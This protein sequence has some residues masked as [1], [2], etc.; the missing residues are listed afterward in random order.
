MRK[1][2]KTLIVVLVLCLVVTAF[3]SCNKITT[4]PTVKPEP[5]HIHAF[6]EAG[7]RQPATCECGETQ[8][9][10]LGHDFVDGVCTRCDE[11]DPEYVVPHEHRF[12]DGKCSCGEEDPNYVP[13]HEHNFVDGKCECGEED[14]NYVV[15]HEHVWS[16]AT[17]TEPKKCECGET[18]G[19]ALGHTLVDVEAAEKTCTT[20]GYSAHKACSNC[21][22]TEGKEV[23]KAGHTLKY[24]VVLPTAESAGYTKVVCEACSDYEEV[25]YDSVNVMTNGS[26]VLDASDDGLAGT[27]SNT[28]VD[29]QVYVHNNV[30]EMH[31]SAKFKVDGSNKTFPDSTFLGTRLNF[32][33]K[34]QFKENGAIINGIV[35]TVADEATVTI[36]WVEGGDDHRQVALYNLAGEIV[37]QSNN[38]EAAKNDPCVDTLTV[39]AGTYVLGNVINTNYIFRVEVVVGKAHEHSYEAVVTAP[40][41]TTTGYTTYTC[42]CGDTYTADETPVADHTFVDGKCECGLDLANL[43]LNLWIS[44]PDLYIVDGHNIK[45]NGAGNT[46][47]CVGSA[48][49]VPYAAGMNTFTITITN[50]GT[51][52]ARVRVDLQGAVEVGNHKVLNTGAVGGDVWTDSDWGGSIVTVP[53][54]ESVTLVI[55]FDANTERGALENL[56]VFVDAMRGDDAVYSSDITISGMG[57]SYVEPHTHSYEEVVTNPTCTEGGYTTYTCEC[58]DTYTGN[59]TEAHGHDYDHVVTAPTCTAAGYTTH[60]CVYCDDSYKDSETEALGHADSNED[61]KCDKCSTKMLPA[62]GTALTIPQALAVAKATGTTYTTQKYYITG[63]ITNVYNTTY[64]N[65]YIKD[66]NGNEICIYGLYDSTGNTRYDAMSYKPVVGDEITVYTVLGMYNTTS[67]GKNAW[68]DDVVAHTHSYEEVVTEPTCTKGGYTTHTCTICNGYV[69]DT[70][71]EALGHTTENGVCERCEQTIGGETPAKETFTADLG[72]LSANTSYGSYKTTSGWQTTNSAVVQGGASNSNPT[73]KALG[74]SATKGVVLNGKTSAKG[75]LV[76]P[77]ISGGVSKLTFNYTNVFSESKGV[78]ITITIKQNGAVVATKQLDNNSVTQYTAY[79]FVWD[80]EAEGIAVTGDFTIE[81]SNNSP[82]NSTSNKDRVAIWN[83]EW[84]NNPVA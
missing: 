13:P 64:G 22:Y 16:E 70:E 14:P 53:A 60:T 9:E 69:I 68:L 79:E 58:G 7:C 32:G 5:E 11:F 39:P 49:V 2:I 34:T 28:Y 18:E 19:E 61:Y 44:N 15:P 74:T 56:I 31:L 6:G 42:E 63:V 78:D 43:Q 82:S 20:D 29:G 21:D 73:F 33:G 36:Y 27:A 66:A 47:A 67:Q 3:A 75:K 8:G 83:I 37:A 72:T 76:S 17:C 71:V 4:K 12:V 38:Q 26:Y 51:V 1:I 48:D 84:T 40:T 30:W 23:V 54:G 77:T 52:D 80:L 50:N 24:T 62:D 65:M 57:F 55:T 45:Y 41:C 81:I 46:Y 59:E 35:F 25:V 10:A